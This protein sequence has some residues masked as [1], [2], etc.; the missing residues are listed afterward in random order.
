MTTATAPDQILL[1]YRGRVVKTRLQFTIVAAAL[2][3]NIQMSS[4]GGDTNP[5]RGS[6]A[7]TYVKTR[8]LAT[9]KTA[10]FIPNLTRT[11]FPDHAALLR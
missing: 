2:F 3:K 7:W 6:D 10:T 1:K 5:L 9:T 11:Q 8:P 4:F